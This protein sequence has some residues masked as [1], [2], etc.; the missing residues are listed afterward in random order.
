LSLVL[1][2]LTGDSDSGVAWV[3]YRFGTNKELDP[4]EIG[5]E[6]G[7]SEPVW[8]RESKRFPGRECDGR[9]NRLIP[10]DKGQIRLGRGCDNR[11]N[12]KTKPVGRK[13]DC[14]RG[15]CR[16][17]FVCFI[18]CNGRLDQ[19]EA[20]SGQGTRRGRKARARARARFF[21][22]LKAPG[23][24]DRGEGCC[25]GR[26]DKL[27]GGRGVRD[28]FVWIRAGK[29]R[30]M[31]LVRMEPPAGLPKR[32][33]SHVTCPSLGCRANGL[34]LDLPTRWPGGVAGLLSPLPHLSQR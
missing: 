27:G 2:N 28:D 26:G 29:V 25:L 16:L 14:S 13:R 19:G 33:P 20:G 34:F 15:R 12:N 8:P 5:R 32:P 4:K 11:S 18:V 31:T 17:Y 9:L 10:G 23:Y 6:G 7:R 1:C 3:R 30:H 24:L 22:S 21:H